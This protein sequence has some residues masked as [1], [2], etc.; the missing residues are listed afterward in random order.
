MW[1]Y[2]TWRDLVSMIPRAGWVKLG[3][4]VAAIVAGIVALVR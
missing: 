4:I 3:L 2:F 1:G